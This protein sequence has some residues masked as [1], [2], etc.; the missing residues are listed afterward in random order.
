M[1]ADSTEVI[2]EP[3]VLAA[4]W[5]TDLAIQGTIFSAAAL[6]ESPEE[7]KSWIYECTICGE[8]FFLKRTCDPFAQ[9]MV[10]PKYLSDVLRRQVAL[11]IKRGTACVGPLLVVE[12]FR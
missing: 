2:A 10:S 7:A 5:Q 1:M 12:Q 3:F 6:R 4:K 9:A 8:R 11:D